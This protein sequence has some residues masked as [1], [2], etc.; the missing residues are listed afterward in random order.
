MEG[1]E[2]TENVTGSN[3]TVH[4][5]PATLDVSGVALLVYA[6]RYLDAAQR[7]TPAISADRFDPVSFQLYCQSIELFLKAYIWSQDENIRLAS[8]RRKYGHNLV[9]LWSDAQERGI[10]NYARCTPLR[11]EVISLVGP[12]YKDRRFC[13]MD[14]GM[15]LGGYKKLRSNP[16]ALATL[17]RLGLQLSRS[18]RTPVS[19]R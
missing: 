1:G 17:R 6:D 15:A 10:G 4:L 13:Y 16:R 18:L 11:D 3:I 2:N 8:I 12:Y 9:R 19:A 5:Q 14:I 7:L